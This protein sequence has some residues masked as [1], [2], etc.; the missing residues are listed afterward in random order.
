MKSFCISVSYYNLGC[1]TALG[2]ILHLRRV[3]LSYFSDL[4]HQGAEVFNRFLPSRHELL[5]FAHRVKEAGC[6][7]LRFAPW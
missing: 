6:I 7:L 2:R 5:Y 4:F 1:A 3:V